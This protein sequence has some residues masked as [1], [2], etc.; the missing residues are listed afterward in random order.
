M[1][2]LLAK[3]LEKLGL[4]DYSELSTVERQTY[5]E[6]ERILSH[7]VRI[8]DVAT[9]LEKQV[10]RLHRELREATKEGEDRQALFKTARIENYEAIIAI[11]KEP[12][13]RRKELERELL[14]NLE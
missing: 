14:N 11:I 9:F 1:K 10:A 2:N 4:Q 3:Y 13:E 8:E 12:N 5:E 7:E 6:W